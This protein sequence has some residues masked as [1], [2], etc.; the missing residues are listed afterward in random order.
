MWLEPLD[1]TQGLVQ[2]PHLVGK[3]TEAP[4]EAVTYPKSLN[5]LL[6]EP[7]LESG[8]ASCFSSAHD[9]TWITVSFGSISLGPSFRP[10]L[11]ASTKCC[12][13]NLAGAVPSQPGVSSFAP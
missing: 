6:P 1:I 2:S 8:S 4:K 5:D 11:A 10:G 7:G 9:A 13:L 3:D 12:F